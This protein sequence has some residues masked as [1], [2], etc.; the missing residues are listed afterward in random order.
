MVL[1][2]NFI[3]KFLVNSKINDTSLGILL[4]ISA[5]FLLSLMDG[6]SKY[7]SQ[8][9]SVIAINMFRY[10]FFGILIF[11]LCIDKK[12][13]K[14]SVP[15]SKFKLI[16]VF[17]GGILAV[18]MCFAHYCFLK[19]GLIE[20][21]AI[22]A[23]CPLIVAVLSIFILK[24]KFGWRRWSAIIFGFLGII[25]IL[26]PGLKIFDPIALIALACSFAFALYQ[27]L[28]RLVSARDDTNVSFFYTGITGFVILSVIGPFFITEV[29]NLDIFFIF[30][31]C[32]LGTG[33]H[34]LMINAFKKAEASVLQ[35]FVYLHL[36]FV[37]FIGVYIFNENIELPVLVGSVMIVFSGLYTF[38]REKIK[39]Q[40]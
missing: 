9:Y 15:K 3:E 28:T 24:E 26:K 8:Y 6:F 16:Q 21:H 29:S 30:C 4:M 27:V 1:N 2:L 23:S 20:T 31:V 22:F 12:Y 40:P 5:I 19:I 11:Y 35:P 33:G 37:T 34:F 36:V 18:E 13:K 14:V 7:L 32:C 38:W 39:N 10:W 25:I 17:R